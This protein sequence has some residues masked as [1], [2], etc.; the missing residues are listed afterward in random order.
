M[1]VGRW[2]LLLSA[3]TCGI[4]IRKDRARGAMYRSQAADHD[5]QQRVDGLDVELLRARMKRS[6][7]AYNAPATPAVRRNRERQVL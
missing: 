4:E 3:M 2:S 7:C 1:K 6:L 5:Q